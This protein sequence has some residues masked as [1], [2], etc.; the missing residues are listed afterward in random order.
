MEKIE[1]TLKKLSKE[2]Y[3]ALTIPRL[4]WEKRSLTKNFGELIAQPL[5]P[6]FGITLG[7]ALRRILLGAVEGAAVTSVIVKGV[8]NEF[9]TL[10]G[11]IE[12]VMQILLNI[13]EIVVRSKDGRPGNM[14][15]SVTGER[16]IRAGDIT[17]DDNLEIIN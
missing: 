4:Q 13:K 3:Q 14:R 9:A 17:S 15:L 1:G 11:V 12:D 10:P 8:N 6:G 7:N 2:E 5:E 16:V